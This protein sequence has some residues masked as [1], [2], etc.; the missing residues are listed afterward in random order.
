MVDEHFG[1]EVVEFVLHHTRQIALDP[2]VVRLEFLVHVL[3]SDARVARHF[4][5]N[6]GQRQTAFLARFRR[7]RLV[8]F[9]DVRI[10]VNLAKTLVF[11]HVFAQRVEVDDGKAD[12]LAD[13][14]CGKSD[15]LGS[16]QRLKHIGNQFVESGI[17]GR[18]VFRNLSQ[19]GLAVGINRQYHLTILRFDDFT[20]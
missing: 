2:L 13:L 16:G 14:R 12:V 4:L 17:V 7:R 9:H 8:D 15:A 1:V 20:I 10:D 11:G 5:V 3:H 6:A 18:D 19:H